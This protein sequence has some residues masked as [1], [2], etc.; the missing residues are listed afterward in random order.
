MTSAG[1]LSR[2]D[3][4]SYAGSEYSV[5]TQHDDGP[6]A[7]INRSMGMKPYDD[8]TQNWIDAA[9]RSYVTEDVLKVLMQSGAKDSDMVEMPIDLTSESEEKKYGTDKGKISLMTLDQY[10]DSKKYIPQIDDPY[11]LVTARSCDDFFIGPPYRHFVK[12]VQS[13]GSIGGCMPNAG[14]Y[15]VRPVIKLKPDTQIQI[16]KKW[17]E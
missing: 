17:T 1:S 5:L 16:V 12:I 3:I 2:G 15:G 8:D 7:I 10:K 9:L 11:W 14:E 13:N 6:V 4:F